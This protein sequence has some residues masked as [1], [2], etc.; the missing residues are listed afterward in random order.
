MLCANLGC[1]N[2]ATRM[3]SCVFMDYSMTR[4]VCFICAERDHLV[5]SV[6]VAIQ[7]DTLSKLYEYSSSNDTIEGD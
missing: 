2:K 1:T 6:G 4:S 3:V 5:V 7:R